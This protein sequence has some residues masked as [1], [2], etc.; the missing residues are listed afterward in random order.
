MKLSKELANLRTQL[1]QAVARE[2]F[3]QAASL[4][5]R[6]KELEKAVEKEGR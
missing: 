2:E 6:I 1:Q 5:D 3:E 4:R